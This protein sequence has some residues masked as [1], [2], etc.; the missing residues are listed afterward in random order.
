M[1]IRDSLLLVRHRGSRRALAG[2]GAGRAASGRRA[3]GRA[4]RG[5]ESLRAK[6]ANSPCYRP[7]LWRNRF[8]LCAS[9]QL[10]GFPGCAALAMHATQSSIALAILEELLSIPQRGFLEG[11]RL[12]VS[13]V[14]E[15]R[16]IEATLHSVR[17]PLCGFPPGGARARSPRAPTAAAAPCRAGLRHGHC[18]VGAGACRGASRLEALFA[19]RGRRAGVRRADF[20]CVVREH[21]VGEGSVFVQ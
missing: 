4:T 1:C 13:E 11:D 15:A 7:E 6:V 20:V 3:S 18:R 21:A 10:L 8:S 14:Q 17:G 2:R 12:S 19:D 5:R 16:M 9:Q